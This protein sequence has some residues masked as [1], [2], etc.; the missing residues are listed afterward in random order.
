[1]GGKGGGSKVEYK[2]SPE[3]RQVWNA[4]MP[5]VN[6]LSAVLGGNPY[7]GGGGIPAVPTGGG[8]GSPLGFDAWMRQNHPNFGQVFNPEAGKWVPHS[9]FGWGSPPDPEQYRPQ[10]N[11]YL[12]GFQASGTGAASGGA[13]ATTAPT[14]LYDIPGVPTPVGKPSAFNFMSPI[15]QYQVPSTQSIMPTSDW[16]GGLAPQVKQGLWAPYN[17]GAQQMLE[18]MGGGGMLGSPSGGMSGAAGAAMGRY[19]QDAA[20]DVGLQAWQMTAPGAFAGWQADLQRGMLGDQR[21][22]GL[23]LQDYQTTMQNAGMM[24]SLNQQAWQQEIAARQMP[25]GIVPGLLGGSYS[26]PVVSQNPTAGQMIGGG[27]MGGL[28]G[29]GMAS[30]FPAMGINPLLGAGVGILGGLFG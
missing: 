11:N 4:L 9:N 21:Q 24:D 28:M 20:K 19:Y 26:Q 3:Q 16:W 7:V 29:Y 22:Y 14:T 8:A 12:S 30:A 17:E 15:P 23:G 5:A 10:Y 13:G 2:Q 1:M 18:Q 27:A 6:Q 25:W